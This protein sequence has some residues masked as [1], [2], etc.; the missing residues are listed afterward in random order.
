MDLGDFRQDI[1]SKPACKKRQ[2]SWRKASKEQKDDF[3]N[4]LDEKLGSIVIPTSVELC[5]DV[6]CCDPNHIEELDNFTMELLQTVQEVAENSLPIPI[7]SQKKQ[8]KENKIPGW[9]EE[10]K[11]FK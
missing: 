7:V 2:P 5:H 4:V 6:K 9:K 3:K 10:V 11:P 1:Q 8:R